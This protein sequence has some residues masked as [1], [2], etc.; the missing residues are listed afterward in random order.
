MLKKNTKKCQK[1]ED[2]RLVAK[3]VPLYTIL[4]TKSYTEFLITKKAKRD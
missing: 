1:M 3:F 4:R 2:K